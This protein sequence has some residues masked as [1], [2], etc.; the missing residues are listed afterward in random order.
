MPAHFAWRHSSDSSFPFYPAFPGQTVDY[1]LTPALAQLLLQG[2]KTRSEGFSCGIDARKGKWA[3][4]LQFE[5][6]VMMPFAVA[7]T[8]FGRRL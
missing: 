5:E 3:E 6:D 8:F 4:S 2:K 7:L 1:G